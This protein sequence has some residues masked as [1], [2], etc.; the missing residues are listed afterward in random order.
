[1]VSFNVVAI[2]VMSILDESKGRIPVLSNPISS[3]CAG[4]RG[5]VVRGRDFGLTR[6]KRDRAILYRNNPRNVHEMI[7]IPNAILGYC[8]T[9]RTKTSN[10]SLSVSHL[11]MGY[12]TCRQLFERP[13]IMSIRE[14]Y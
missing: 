7:C 3:R 11:H 12:S 2:G 8:L 5:I 13:T 1:M 10:I 9:N 6:G 4:V 14:I